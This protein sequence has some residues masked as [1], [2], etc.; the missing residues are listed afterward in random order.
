MTPSKSR[1]ARHTASSP[2]T[3]T[4]SMIRSMDLRNPGSKM[5]SSPLATQRGTFGLGH[6]LPGHSS[7]NSHSR[8][9]TCIAAY[10]R[11]GA[12]GFRHVPLSA[13]WSVCMPV[14]VVVGAQWGDEGKAKVIDLLV[15]GT[16]LRC[17]L[18]GRPQRR[19]HRCRWRRALRA[20][21]H[22]QWH[23]VRPC[24]PGHR[25]WGRRRSTHPC[26]RRSTR[27]NGAASRA[28]G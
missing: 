15:Q 17:S 9:G 10:D 21:T 22:P 27:L 18:S 25:Q 16:R 19:S 24:R 13:S 28:I 23:S 5:S 3:R 12:L 4:S 6:R 7:Q 2:L 1:S 11:L 14:T 8:N 20:A 26:S